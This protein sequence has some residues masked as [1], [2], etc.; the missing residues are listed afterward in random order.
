MAKV[1]NIIEAIRNNDNLDTIAE[2]LRKTA[3][4]PDVSDFSMTGGQH[5][6]LIGSI[7]SLHH[8]LPPPH[9]YQNNIY[10]ESVVPGGP[11]IPS[12][13]SPLS[14]DP[15]QNFSWSPSI[16]GGIPL[17][18]YTETDQMDYSAGLSQLGDRGELYQYGSSNYNSVNDLYYDLSQ[19]FSGSPVIDGSIPLASDTEV[20]QLYY[21]AGCSQ[22]GEQWQLYQDGSIASELAIMEDE[23]YSG[24]LR[25]GI[26]NHRLEKAPLMEGWER[27]RR[28][29]GENDGI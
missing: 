3:N 21:P 4:V 11:S 8:R 27:G 1:T 24:G 12:L 10:H 20:G 29:G 6:Q 5:D 23:N 9:P 26:N 25:E 17:A 18:K 7:G 13:A 28:R 2:K 16:D 22:P 15:S 14:Y 19:N